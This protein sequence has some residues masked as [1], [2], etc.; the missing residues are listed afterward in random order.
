MPAA[1]GSESSVGGV[2]VSFVFGA[3]SS[4]S[5]FFKAVSAASSSENSGGCSVGGFFAASAATF[6]AASSGGGLFGTAR[7]ATP[8]VS[9]SESSGG[10]VVAAGAA[11]FG[12]A[13]RDGGFFGAA[14]AA[15]SG[16]ESRPFGPLRAK[17]EAALQDRSMDRADLQRFAMRNCMP[18]RHVMRSFDAELT[19][20]IQAALEFEDA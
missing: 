3:E 8:A 6:G 11:T 13:S 20:Y 16:S 14:S 4:G 5:G 15:S 12:S 2:S 9:G 7:G 19:A 18:F 1:S 10:G 17:F